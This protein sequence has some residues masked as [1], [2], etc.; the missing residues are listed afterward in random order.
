LD[1]TPACPEEF[2][3]MNMETLDWS[4]SADS[5]SATPMEFAQA[6]PYTPAPGEAPPPLATLADPAQDSGRLKEIG[7]Q[8]AVL[9]GTGG[10]LAL[11]GGRAVAGGIAS[12]VEKWRN[13]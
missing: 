8:V 11:K 10:G 3:P 7:K 9:V 5:A 1:T 2:A 6:I 13:R 12:L 4:P